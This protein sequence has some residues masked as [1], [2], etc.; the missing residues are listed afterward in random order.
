MLTFLFFALSIWPKS[1]S[2][3]RNQCPLSK[4]VCVQL[5]MWVDWHMYIKKATFFYSCFG[6]SNSLWNCEF[7]SIWRN[8]LIE[9]MHTDKKQPHYFLF[10]PLSLAKHTYAPYYCDECFCPSYTAHLSLI[11]HNRCVEK[12]DRLSFF[13]NRKWS[14]GGCC[15]HTWT[16]FH[17]F[18]DIR[19]QIQL[20][21]CG[22][23]ILVIVKLSLLVI[24][25]PWILRY[26]DRNVCKCP[27]VGYG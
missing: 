15:S 2:L 12:R 21:F 11:K 17:L 5:W 3:V 16:S 4:K 9:G 27:F 26:I 22:C 6:R 23:L 19:E 10:S 13:L 7:Q 14:T 1:V 24:K 18:S 8:K 25:A 20:P